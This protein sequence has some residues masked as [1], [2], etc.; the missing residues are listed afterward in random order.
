MCKLSLLYLEIGGTDFCSHS[1]RLLDRG[2]VLS[3][4]P[5]SENTDLKANDAP[6]VCV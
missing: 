5:S 6:V 1:M 2:R 4:F 3:Q